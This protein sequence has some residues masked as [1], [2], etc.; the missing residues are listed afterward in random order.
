MS[1]E[2]EERSKYRLHVAESKAC[3]YEFLSW[4][5]WTGK[6]T[7]RELAEARLFR[8]YWPHKED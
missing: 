3:G 8:K 1:T 7:S 2:D 5:E 6:V 4:D